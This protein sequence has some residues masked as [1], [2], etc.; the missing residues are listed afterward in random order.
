MAINKDTGG[1]VHHTI[2]LW[3]L[4]QLIIAVSLAGASRR[5][6]RAAVPA[7]AGITAIVAISGALVINQ[8]Y[9]KAWRNGGAV[10]WTDGIV[11]LSDYFKQNKPPGWVLATDWSIAD[12][13]RLL[14]RGRILI[15][16]GSDQVT[17][18]EMNTEDREVL[19]RMLAMQDAIWVAHAPEFQI[20]PGAN[21]KLLNFATLSGFRREPI[22][23]IPD[24]YGRNVYDVYRFVK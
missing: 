6:G 18:P 8:Y 7:A 15:G 13:I 21:E 9:V 10:F 22:A 3:P 2:L 19:G 20:I 23:V 17:K 5:L 1:S 16:S 11:K 14:H 24:N 12:Q 4:P